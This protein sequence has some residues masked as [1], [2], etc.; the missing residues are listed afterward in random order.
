MS[1]SAPTPN[2]STLASHKHA[3]LEMYVTRYTDLRVTK[4]QAR[5]AGPFVEWQQLVSTNNRRQAMSIARSLFA[6]GLF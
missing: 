6:L 4:V 3:A 2:A 1:A 5:V